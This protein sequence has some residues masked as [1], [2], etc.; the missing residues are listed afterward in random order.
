MTNPVLGLKR[1]V[2]RLV[3]AEKASEKLR[4]NSF[5]EGKV[6]TDAVNDSNRT[7]AVARKRYRD[8]VARI[9]EELRRRPQL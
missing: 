1:A 9:E 3:A 6:T 2:T 7:L 5:Y 4:M 8:A